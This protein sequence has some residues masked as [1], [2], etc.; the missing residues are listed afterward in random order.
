MWAWS[1][2]TS[3]ELYSWHVECSPNFFSQLTWNIVYAWNGSQAWWGLLFHWQKRL[4]RKIAG[5]C[6]L[7]SALMGV[8]L[9]MMSHR[10]S[11]TDLIGRARMLVI[12]VSLFRAQM[13]KD[14]KRCRTVCVPFRP[15]TFVLQKVRLYSVSLIP[16]T[17]SL[18]QLGEAKRANNRTWINQ[19]STSVHFANFLNKLPYKVITVLPLLACKT[20]K[21][22]SLENALVYLYCSSKTRSRL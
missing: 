22:R 1:W 3:I 7:P 9:A 4:W 13:N 17:Y 18:L 14:K 2:L 8:A 6:R 21:A 15:C 20:N 5:V 16:F 12:P 11:P 10:V 19:F